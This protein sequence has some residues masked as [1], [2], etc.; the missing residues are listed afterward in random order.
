MP[1]KQIVLL[2]KIREEFM[3]N[4]FKISTKQESA[5]KLKRYY[6]EHVCKSMHTDVY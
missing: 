3:C 6:G 5:V 4:V 1:S 2:G